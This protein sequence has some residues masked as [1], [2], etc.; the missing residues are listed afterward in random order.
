VPQKKGEKVP[1]PA[2]GMSEAPATIL[3]T[4][5]AE[6][7]LLVDGTATTSTSSQRRLVSPAL[8]PGRDYHYTL[9]AEISREGQAPIRLTQRVTVRAGEETRVPFT[10]TD[11]A[12]TASR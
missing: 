2:S 4:L 8:Q 1:P 6:A 11:P 5:P 9:T 12:V 7:K 3:V 10:F